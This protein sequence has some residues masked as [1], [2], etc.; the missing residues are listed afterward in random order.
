M[1]R[2]FENPE[3]DYRKWDSCIANSINGIIYPY[4]FYLDQVSFGWSALVLNE[5][6]AVMPLP[7][8]I[9][10]GVNYIIQPPFVQQLGVY[11]PYPITE[12]LLEEFLNAIP[13][14]FSYLNISL[15]TFNPL[16]TKFSDKVSRGITYEL[17]LIEPYEVIRAKYSSQTIRNLKTAAREGISV[18]Q[19][20]EPISTIEAFKIHNA[21]ENY[22]YT[23]E[24]Y[25]VLKRL[26][27][28]L[29]YK[30]LGTTYTAYDQ[31]NNFCSGIIFF[32][33][34]K[35][36][37]LIFSGS[38]PSARKNGAMTAII[39]KFIKDHSGQSLTLDFEGSTNKNL[40]R[41]YAGFGSK[42]CVFLQI[43]NKRFPPIFKPFANIYL[44][45]KQLT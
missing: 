40:A 20:N 37:I 26:A 15:N 38:Y 43:E 1:I 6:E 12:E 11:S 35:K 30:G 39:D 13:R 45:L 9:K 5:Y 2:Y 27:Y 4:S 16:T 17:D 23:P 29:I 36:S 18:V 19:N 41:F 31:K 33:S 24:H 25:N 3:I 10:M 22:N 32:T 21:K 42:E 44:W 7:V 14:K 28:S 34:H 8:K